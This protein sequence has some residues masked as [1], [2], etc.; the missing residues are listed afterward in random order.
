VTDLSQ[1]RSVTVTYRMH[2]D[3]WLGTFHTRVVEPTRIVLHPGAAA[4]SVVNVGLP[5]AQQNGCATRAWLVKPPMPGDTPLRS[6]GHRPE[7]CDASYL[8]ES[9][10]YP[11][12][13]PI[14][15]NYRPTRG[16]VTATLRATPRG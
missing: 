16:T 12:S 9:P 4:V 7:M 14:T 13:V 11:P 5:I 8:T 2:F 10:L 3:E 15:K 1:P 6:G